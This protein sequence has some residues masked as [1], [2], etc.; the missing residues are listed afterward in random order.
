MIPADTLLIC[1]VRLVGAVPAP[2]EPQ[3]TGRGRRRT[4]TDRLFVKAVLVMSLR[5]LHKAHELLSVLEQ[6][7]PEMQALREALTEGGA[8]PSRRTWERRLGALAYCLPA[9]VARLGRHLVALLNPWAAHGRAA[10]IDSTLLRARGG[11][12]HKKDREAGVV[13]HT[14]IDTQAAWSKSGWH[15]WVYGWKLHL[16]SATGDVWI[17]LAADLTPANRADNEQALELLPELPPL[18]L[19]VLGD[20]HYN[21]PDVRAACRLR[22]CTLVATRR[23]KYPHTD[24]GVE[25]RRVFHSLRSRAIENFNEQFKGIFDA[26]EQV[27]TRGLAQTKR[28]ALGAV[29]AYQVALLYRH[30]HGLS[31]RQGLKPFLR[32]A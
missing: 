26:H 29:F 16:I 23:G 11:V 5:R 13:P 17:P 31:L 10:A 6:P 20:T 18:P 21:A 22:G 1:L 2:P 3:T 12:W 28:F 30:E 19:F 32:A 15:G 9:W 14:R 7:T 24:A 27:P 25:V 8:F 4:Y